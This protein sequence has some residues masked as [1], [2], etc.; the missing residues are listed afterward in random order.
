MARK[1]ASRRM[2]KRPVNLPRVGD[3]GLPAPTY[4]GNNVPELVEAAALYGIDTVVNEMDE[5][6]LFNNT[7][8]MGAKAS[9]VLK[10]EHC[11]EHVNMILMSD[12]TVGGVNFARDVRWCHNCFQYFRYPKRK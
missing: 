1:N 12:R 9:E 6:Q 4:I 5:D 11:W 8:S 3:I 10:I 2:N 7:I